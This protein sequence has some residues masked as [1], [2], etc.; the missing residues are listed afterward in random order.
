V[1]T[2][3]N[4][5]QPAATVEP[6]VIFDRVSPFT[7]VLVVDEGP[8]RIMRFGGLDGADQSAI[9]RGQPGAVP[10]EYIRYALLGLA[11]HGRP[12]RVLMVGLGGGTFSTVVHRALPEVIIDVVEIDPVVVEAARTYF[13]VRPDHR[14][15]IHLAD[16]ATFMARGD[17]DYDYVLLDA[18]AGDDIPA[19]L[20]SE[21]FF[22][23]VRRRL[24][25]GGVVG[26]NI[27][28]L[29]GEGMKVA[30]AFGA[31]LDLFDCRQTP[32]DGNTLIF[33]AARPRRV[34]RVAVLAWAA[35]WDARGVTSFS[36]RSVAETKAGAE[37]QKVPLPAA[38]AKRVEFSPHPV[39][40]RARR[41][42]LL[43]APSNAATGMSR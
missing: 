16:A 6:Q 31:V 40:P 26:I 38:P 33:A 13:G 29:D 41:A 36:L 1:K 20:A 43:H 9:V 42:R 27:S 14:Y 4:D 21:A 15:R 11:H 35:R 23:S 8:L 3:E 12:A 25:P 17:A 2:P 5:P 32:I 10:L 22:R 24:A 39:K 34:D 30:R 37:C 28:E 7:R 18:Y 19:E